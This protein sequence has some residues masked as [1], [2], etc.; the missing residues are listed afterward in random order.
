ME[1]FPTADQALVEFAK[2][3]GEQGDMAR[4]LLAN[5]AAQAARL[6]EMAASGDWNQALALVGS[7][8]RAEWL[9]RAL[10]ATGPDES[11]ELLAH[12]FNMVDAFGEHAPAFRA[13]FERLTYVSDDEDGNLP[14]FPLTVYRA[15]WGKDPKPDLALS[16]TARL[17]VAERFAKYLTG[18]RAWF[19]GIKREDD[20]PWIWEAT[21]HGAHG[22]FVSRDEEEIVPTRVTGLR[23]IAKL[24]TVPKEEA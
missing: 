24:I 23:P 17:D 9:L 15:Q 11:R 10:R 22:W 8:N 14:D 6:E 3:D 19:L 7:E 18:P 1:A 20:E 5:K 2:L 4:E 13:Q 16:W 21:A 12:W